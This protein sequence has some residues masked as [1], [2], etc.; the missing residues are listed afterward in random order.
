MSRR[1]PIANRDLCTVD[2]GVANGIPVS[3][4]AERSIAYIMTHP[5]LPQRNS[6]IAW[7]VLS[8]IWARITRGWRCGPCTGW[9]C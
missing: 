9:E 4:E 6:R 8:E 5:E 1:M 7:P 2:R 3:R